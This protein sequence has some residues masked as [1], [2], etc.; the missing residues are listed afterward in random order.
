MGNDSGGLR[1]VSLFRDLSDQTLERIARAASRH[2]SAPG[3]MIILEGEPCRAVYFIVDGRVRVYRLS[4]GGR[5]QVLVE[6]AAGDAFNTVPPFQDNPINHATAQ[7]IS[8]TALLTIPSERVR[9]LVQECPDLALAVLHDFAER[10]DH[11]TRLVEG[12]A[13]RTVSG[14]MARFLLDHAEGSAVAKQ[15]TQEEIAAHLGTVRDMIGR[16]LRNF[17]DEGLIG[18]ERQRIVLLDRAGLEAE[19]ER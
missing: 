18:L 1:R 4:P 16:T 5:E 17:A 8:E 19:A 7:A 2:T 11:L 15:W 6:L 12:L 9:T 13:L 3:E 14:R 10:L